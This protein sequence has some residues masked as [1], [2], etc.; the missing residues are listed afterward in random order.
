[1]KWD[2]ASIQ[3]FARDAGFV[4]PDTHTATAIAMA[5]TGGLDHYDI[6]CGAP[7]SGR[8][9]GL[10]AINTDAWPELS[11]ESLLNPTGAARAAYELTRRCAGF[12][13]SDVWKAGT[14]RRWLDHAGVASSMEPFTPQ[15]HVPIASYALEP[16]FDQLTRHLTERHG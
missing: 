10:W 11:P 13:W 3:K 7:G 4:D 12:G 6:A 16:H 14:D 15:H 5:G 8:Y 1:M 9:V 2:A